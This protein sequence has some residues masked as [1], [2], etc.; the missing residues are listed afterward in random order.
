MLIYQMNMLKH[1]IN[2][3]LIC[4]I[5]GV[6]VQYVAYLFNMWLFTDSN[7]PSEF[8]KAL[9][10]LINLWLFWWIFWKLYQKV[11]NETGFSEIYH[12]NKNKFIDN[13]KMMKVF[14]YTIPKYLIWEPKALL[15]SKNYGTVMFLPIKLPKKVKYI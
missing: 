14:L 4:S 15:N 10:N 8:I 5:C 1:L 2:M 7:V 12:Y 9:K 3:W 11:I 6:F 13:L